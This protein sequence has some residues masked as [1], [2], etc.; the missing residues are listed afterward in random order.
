[1]YRATRERS[2]LAANRCVDRLLDDRTLAS[3]TSGESPMSV[4]ARPLDDVGK[5]LA[6]ILTTRV[7]E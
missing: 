2:K 1:V 5:V 4:A 7:R 6:N 3:S